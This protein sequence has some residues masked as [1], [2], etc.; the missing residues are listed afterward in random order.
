VSFRCITSAHHA[1]A[2]QIRRLYRVI[3]QIGAIFPDSQGWMDSGRLDWDAITRRLY[4]L[5]EF[6]LNLSKFIR[7]KAG[8][9]SKD[10]GGAHRDGL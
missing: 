2:Q 6:G 3:R 8:Q 9:F 10:L 7:T 4:K 1:L 5:P